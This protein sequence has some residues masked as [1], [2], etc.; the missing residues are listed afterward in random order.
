MNILFITF[1]VVKHYNV[2]TDS[3]LLFENTNY[4]IIFSIVNY[5]YKSCY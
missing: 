2:D 3:L 1:F 4:N 5:S